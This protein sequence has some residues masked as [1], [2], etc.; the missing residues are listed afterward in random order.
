MNIC[1]KCNEP[2]V[3]PEGKDYVICGCG[4]VIYIINET[5]DRETKE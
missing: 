1:P 4:E 3:V 5:H 2:I